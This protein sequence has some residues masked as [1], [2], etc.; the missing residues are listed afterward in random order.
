MQNFHGSFFATNLSKRKFC[1]VE[2][3]VV[4]K[5][6]KAAAFCRCRHKS[7]ISNQLYISLITFFSFP[8]KL[9][10]LWIFSTLNVR[11]HNVCIFHWIVFVNTF[12]CPN[13]KKK[14]KHARQA[15]VCSYWVVSMLTSFSSS[16]IKCPRINAA[17]ECFLLQLLHYFRV[18]LWRRLS[19]KQCQRQT[20][21]WCIHP[22]THLLFFLFQTRKKCCF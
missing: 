18:E 20:F 7:R 14:N 12:L 4:K 15:L 2:K 3:E 9:I 19:I 16:N 21:E 10:P 5:E 6:E 1:K 8:E 13:L 17:F 22:T 11:W